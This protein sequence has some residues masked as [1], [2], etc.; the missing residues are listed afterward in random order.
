MLLHIKLPAGIVETSLLQRMMA[1][2][3]DVRGV[4]LPFVLHAG[5]C[6][7]Y[8]KSLYEPSALMARAPHANAIMFWRAPDN[9]G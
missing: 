3:E 6:V 1:A 4:K 8:T 9:T 2:W 7:H 5:V